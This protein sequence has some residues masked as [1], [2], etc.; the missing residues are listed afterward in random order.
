MQNHLLKSPF[1][2]HPKT[3]RV[4]VPID[5]TKVPRPHF[6]AEW[7][8]RAC[9]FSSLLVVWGD[10][11]IDMCSDAQTRQ[12]WEFDPMAVPTLGVL[13]KEIN[14]FDKGGKSA[15]SKYELAPDLEKVLLCNVKVP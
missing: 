13:E 15:K 2:V 1:C 11:T 8:Q 5:P 3:G 12:A 7:P 14:A 4:C 6:P 9:V 10:T